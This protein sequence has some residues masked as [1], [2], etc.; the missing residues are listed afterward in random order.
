MRLMVCF[1]SIHVIE[2]IDV[3]R[4]N[5]QSPSELGWRLRVELRHARRFETTVTLGIPFG[6]MDSRRYRVLLAPS[7]LPVFTLRP[8]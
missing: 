4:L 7:L 2:A 8:T 1:K 6:P 3:P 5:A